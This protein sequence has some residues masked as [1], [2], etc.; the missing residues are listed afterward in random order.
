MTFL[1]FSGN[2]QVSMP[3]VLSMRGWK[4]PPIVIETVFIMDS[5]DILV[6]IESRLHVAETFRFPQ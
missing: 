1:K 6:P 3:C 4:T 2:L 5:R